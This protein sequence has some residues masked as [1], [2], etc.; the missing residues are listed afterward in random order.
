MDCLYVVIA[1]A[2]STIYAG[3]AM[4]HCINKGLYDQ[5]TKRSS[6]KQP[7][8]RGGGYSFVN[9]ISIF[10]LIWLNIGE[11]S[12][13]LSFLNTLFLGGIFISYLGWLDDNHN[14]NPLLRLSCHIAMVSICTFMLPVLS[15]GLIPFWIEKVLI[16]LAWVWFLNL[17]NF[18]DG[19][20]GIAATQA[21]ILAFM[22]SILLPEIKPI[23]LVIIGCM[24]GFLRFNWHPARIFMGD[25]GSTYLGFVLGGLFI[26]NLQ[27]NFVGEIWVGLIITSVFVVDATFTLIKRAFN[28]KKPWQAHKEHFYQRAVLVGMSHEDVVKRVI[29]LNLLFMIFALLAHLTHL[30]MPL[31]II[32]LVILASVAVRI[33]YLEGK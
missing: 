11:P 30:G 23:M 7:T 13:H 16:V 6:H 28:G 18:M 8:P 5:V 2:F 15:G 9:V 1:F 4:R 22:L 10:A 21:A 26:Y 25:V 31:F 14:I 20:D 24:V 27:F 32:T 3:K 19:I 29:V 33:R 12:A 17:Y